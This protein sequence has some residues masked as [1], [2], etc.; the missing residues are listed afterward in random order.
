M[1]IAN[2]SPIVSQVTAPVIGPLTDR[3]NSL[4]V[5]SSVTV[6]SENKSRGYFIFQNISDATM[7]LNFG[8]AA[9][10]NNNSI[11]V[12]AQG[13][14]LFTGSFIPNQEINVL[15]PTASGGSIKRF[16]AKEG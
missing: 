8:A 14:V 10:A 2:F 9:T 5:A 1:N 6:A 16:I 11:L 7:W 13:S 3:S 15:C 4:A 12:A